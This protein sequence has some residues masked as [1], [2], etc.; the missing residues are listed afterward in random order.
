MNRI[1]KIGKTL[2][3]FMAEATAQF[4]RSAIATGRWSTDT[5]RQWCID[6]FDSTG[7]LNRPVYLLGDIEVQKKTVFVVDH[8]A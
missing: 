7:R 4:C 6:R 3:N 2:D 1:P 5:I 8:Y